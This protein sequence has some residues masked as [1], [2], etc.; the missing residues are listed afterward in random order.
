[1][2]KTI[3]FPGGGYE[4][5]LLHKDDI[6]KTIDENIIDKEVAYAFVADCE[7][8]CAEYLAEGKWGAIPFM[9]NFRILKGKILVANKIRAELEKLGVEEIPYE[10]YSEIKRTMMQAYNSAK[11]FNTKYK[12]TLLKLLRSNKDEFIKYKEKY[13]DINRAYFQFYLD[14]KVQTSF[15]FLPESIWLKV[16]N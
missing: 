4:V 8:R 16:T 12:T 2:S 11:I 9:G 7:K 3:H 1:M 14:N 10:E 6:L 15:D 5:T 13:E